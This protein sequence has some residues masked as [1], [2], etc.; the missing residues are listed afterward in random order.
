MNIRLLLIYLLPYYMALDYQ[1]SFLVSSTI[2]C[3]SSWP[4]LDLTTGHY[5]LK[6]YKDTIIHTTSTD[7][8]QRDLN[9]GRVIRI[10]RGST[11]L[12]RN[13]VIS[14]GSDLLYAVSFDSQVQVWNLTSGTLNGR[15]VIPGGSELFS[16]A[17]A[18]SFLL[19]G[20]SDSKINR[21]NLQNGRVT[22]FFDTQTG[23]VSVMLV[24][25]QFLIAGTVSSPPRLGRWRLNSGALEGTYPG[26]TSSITTLYVENDRLFSGSFDGV[27]FKW[28]YIFFEIL[29]T[30][31]SKQQ[32]FDLLF[33]TD[34]WLVCHS[35][36]QRKA[37]CRRS[38]RFRNLRCWCR[39]HK[40]SSSI[41]RC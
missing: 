15:F 12:I 9:T 10:L 29:A 3:F 19:V 35:R 40:S 2:Y 30:Y 6:V 1:K 5:C 11:A 33:S 18:Q 8:Y 38:C 31:R 20:G 24:Y 22:Q 23:T 26:H 16:I 21:L 4:C 27:V 13:F 39:V 36:Q 37:L 28:D 17:L 34:C 25:S 14:N 7:L 32:P 41:T